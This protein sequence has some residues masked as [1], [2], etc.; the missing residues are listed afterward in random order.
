MNLDVTRLGRAVVPTWVLD[1][2]RRWIGSDVSAGVTLAVLLVPQTLAYAAL[3]NMPPITGL[4]AALVSLLVYALFGTSSTMSYGPFALISLL[5]AAALAPLSN[6]E[7]A[8]FVALAGA[9]AVMVGVVHLVLAVVRA[10]AVIALISYPVI[11]GYTAAVAVIIGLSQ[12]RDLTGV[13]APRT[14]RVVDAVAIA[15][16]HLPDVHLPTLLLGLTSLAALVVGPR[17][18]RRLPM[19]LLVCVFGAAGVLMFRLDDVG[20]QVVG[21]VP[22]G[23]PRFRIPDVSL[24][25][26]RA[27]IGPALVIGLIAYTSNVSIVKAIAARSR[28]KVDGTRELVASGLSNVGAGLLG[29][30]PVAASFSRTALLFSIGAR[31]QLAGVVAAGGVLLVLLVLARAL[32]PIPRTVL[33]AIII[34]A[35]SGLVD[36]RA[37]RAVFRLDR[38]DGTIMVTAFVATLLFGVQIGLAVGVGVNLATH[39]SRRMRPT[40]VVL[41]RVLGTNVYRNVQRYPTASQPHDGLILRLDSA[42][43]FLSAEHVARAVLDR[44]AGAPDLRWI[45]L[46]VGAMTGLDATGIRTLVDLKQDLATWDVALHLVSLR[47]SERDRIERA[48]LWAQLAGDS[49]HPNVAMALDAIGVDPQDPVRRP[50]PTEQPPDVVF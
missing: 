26:L 49:C 14:E 46:D 17:V 47:G 44:I 19:T 42:M 9:L 4:Y 21:A 28:E 11:V 36:L 5:T 41:G 30:F 20:V 16:R 15:V 50:D 2:D 22:A 37:A 33:A 1:Y 29:G 6:Q 7:T 40:L 10:D 18:S 38:T 23:L 3:A 45:I 12:F 8:H 39:V 13:D 24:T 27:L 34:V 48:G 31:S 43:D 25:D 32:E 35:I